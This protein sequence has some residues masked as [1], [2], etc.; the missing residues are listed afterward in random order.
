MEVYEGPGEGSVEG[1]DRGLSFRAPKSLLVK[2]E[3]SE[4]SVPDL[5]R[6]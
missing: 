2:L 3:D 6:T 5:L 1:G 4:D